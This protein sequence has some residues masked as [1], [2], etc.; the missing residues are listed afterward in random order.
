MSSQAPGIEHVF[1]L[2]LE[3]RSFDHLL[4]SPASAHRRRHGQDTGINGLS[5][6]ESNQFGGATYTVSEGA[7]RVMP[8]DPATSFRTYSRS[9]AGP[10][11]SIQGAAPIRRSKPADLWRLT[12]R[13]AARTPPK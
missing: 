3:N 8:T 4:V 10:G 7:D 13:A 5:G 11:R 1:V 9:S 2:M 12:W 6:T